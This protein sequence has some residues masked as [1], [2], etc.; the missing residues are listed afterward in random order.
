M[1][2]VLGVALFKIFLAWWFIGATW[3][4][5]SNWRNTRDDGVRINPL[6]NENWSLK[7]KYVR[8]NVSIL[9]NKWGINDLEVSICPLSGSPVSRLASRI[10]SSNKCFYTTMLL[11]FPY[12]SPNYP[13]NWT[14]VEKKNFIGE[15]LVWQ[16]SREN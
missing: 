10:Y 14:V 8:G 15:W 16:I 5:T 11:V 2:N 6:K 1:K 4:P 12:A 7:I 13:Q 9:G 3:S